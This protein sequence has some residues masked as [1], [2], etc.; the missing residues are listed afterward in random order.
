[1]LLD[2]RVDVEIDGHLVTRQKA[3]VGSCFLSSVRPI[4]SS[5]VV[6]SARWTGSP[7]RKGVLGTWRRPR[8]S[9]YRSH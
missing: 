8:S 3:D 9:R 2:H 1:M 7:A 6:V 4:T 5:I